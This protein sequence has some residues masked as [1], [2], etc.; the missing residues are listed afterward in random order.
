MEFDLRILNVVH[1]PNYMRL[2]WWKTYAIW[3]LRMRGV[4][5]GVSVRLLGSPIVSLKKGSNI[6]LGDRV[7]LCSNSDYT[8]LGVNHPV[9][10]RTLT[11]GAE[12]TIGNDVGISGAT[13]CAAEGI[14]IGEQCL[15]GANVTIVDTDFHQ[16]HPMN[17]RY[18]NEPSNVR[19]SAVNIGRNV[20]I[21]MG[22]I[23]LKGVM[24]GENS[25]IGAGSVVSRN[26]PP[27]SVVAGNP[28]VVIKQIGDT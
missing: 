26:V 16:P 8:A 21:G 23:I 25:I 20:F 24:I 1:Y 6:V 9:I 27:N 11:R 18:S 28:A 4:S 2:L 15:I 10:L 19:T 12:I 3:R 14:T 7:V 22:S 13:I 5:M 17:R